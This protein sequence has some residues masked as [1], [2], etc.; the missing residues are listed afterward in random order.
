MTTESPSPRRFLADCLDRVPPSGIRDFFDIVTSMKDVISL[1]I[2]EPDFVAP[3]NIRE[4]SVFALER[5]A[6]SY[7]S[8]Q[9]TP[10]F[11][12]RSPTT[13]AGATTQITTRTPRC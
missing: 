12:K 6:T 5:G 3:W 2:G 9:G 13:S 10:K 1:G 8:N 11:A 7:T 4:A